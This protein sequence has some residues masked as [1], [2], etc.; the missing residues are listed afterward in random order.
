MFWLLA[1]EQYLSQAYG[2][3][4]GDRAHIGLLRQLAFMLLTILG[5]FYGRWLLSEAVELRPFRYLQEGLALGD[6]L[7]IGGAIYAAT[8][9][10]LEAAAAVAQIIP[11]ALWLAVRVVFLIR[12]TESRSSA[13]ASRSYSSA[14]L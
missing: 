10:Q 14:S 2:V 9:G 8:V 1:P 12:Q 13:S 5:W 3:T 11:A 7:I 4:V 6:V